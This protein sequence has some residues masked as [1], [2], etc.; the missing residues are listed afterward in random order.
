MR[1]A[2]LALAALAAVALAGTLTAQQ[3]PSTPAQA[4]A[5][6]APAGP[7]AG[8]TP[9]AGADPVPGAGRGGRQGGRGGRGGG[10]QVQPGQACPP[11]TTMA[12]PQVCRAPEF[13]PPSIIDY[14][15]RTTLVVEQHPVPRAKFPAID[16][17]GHG[18]NRL[19]SVEGLNGLVA[20]L[21]KLNVGLFVSADNSTGDTL[22]QRLEVLRNS[23][24]KDRVRI[25]TGVQFG[26][27]ADRVPGF[28][29]RAL[30]SCST[31]FRTSWSK[32]A[33]FSTTWGVSRVRLGHS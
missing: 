11:G 2:P 16:I 7:V 28:G 18:G 3:S 14:R 19:N 10:I 1:R 12:Q 30:A 22:R 8:T 26:A 24:H 25:L 5:P 6:A 17:H 32:E 4:P 33:P 15:P 9:P 21:D 13:P 29:A 23:P 20:E 31:R 27:Q